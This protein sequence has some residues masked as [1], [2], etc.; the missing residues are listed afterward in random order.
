[1]CDKGHDAYFAQ[2]AVL[3]IR[4]TEIDPRLK[5]SGCNGKNM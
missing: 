2:R 5:I 4:L 3:C 1:M